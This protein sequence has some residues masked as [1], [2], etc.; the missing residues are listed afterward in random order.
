MLC[1]YCPHEV[2]CDT[3]HHVWHCRILFNCFSGL[4][5]PPATVVKPRCDE[6]QCDGAHVKVEERHLNRRKSTGRSFDYG[7]MCPL[8]VTDDGD[9]EEI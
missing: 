1:K 9:Y 5:L 7:L 6:T 8:E 4:S 2:L 3:C